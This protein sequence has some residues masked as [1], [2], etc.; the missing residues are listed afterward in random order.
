MAEEFATLT[1]VTAYTGVN[2]SSLELERAHLLVEMLGDRDRT[3][4][5]D[6]RARDVR[7]LK[8]AT[9]YAAAYLHEHPE[10]LL[11]VAGIGSIGQPDLSISYDTDDEGAHLVGRA[12]WKAIKGLSWNR[13]RSV[14]IGS[15]LTDRVLGS[16]PV[17]ASADDSGV[18]VPF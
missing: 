14:Q 8:A 3:A 17:A 15:D 1:D 10:I 6:F 13:S 9:A 4:V 18:W 7:K 11:E 5:A 12:A 2:V 16:I